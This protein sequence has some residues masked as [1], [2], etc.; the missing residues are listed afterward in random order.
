M[1]DNRGCKCAERAHLEGQQNLEDV[2]GVCA[3]AG[4]YRDR[5]VASIQ[6]RALNHLSLHRNAV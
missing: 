4:A 2:R 6:V 1:C 5:T 3:F